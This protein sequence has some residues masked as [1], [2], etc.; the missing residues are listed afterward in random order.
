MPSLS[1]AEIILCAG[2]AIVAFFG[3][4]SALVLVLF[5]REAC[6]RCHARI[7]KRSAVCPRC[8][9]DLPLGWARR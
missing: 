4:L 7:P 3:P 9:R 2:V 1:A 8:R 6:P 5:G